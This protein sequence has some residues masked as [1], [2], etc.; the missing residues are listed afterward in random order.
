MADR[1]ISDAQASAI[2]HALRPLGA[3]EFTLITYDGRET[4]AIAVRIRDILTGMGWNSIP[5]RGRLI[6]ADTG[7]LVYAS[8]TADLA[9]KRAAHALVSALATMDS[10][11]REKPEDPPKNRIE[12]I[13]GRKR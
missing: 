11:Y 1:S 13:I 8:A 4:V 10:E 7:I 2:T 5:P 6:G 9:V 12:I 3:Q